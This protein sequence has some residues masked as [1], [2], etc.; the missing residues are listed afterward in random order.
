MAESGPRARTRHTH[1]LSL[2]PLSSLKACKHIILY[3]TSYPEIERISPCDPSNDVGQRLPVS[4]LT[5]HWIR[6][7]QIKLWPRG[8]CS[9]RNGGA[10]DVLA[11]HTH[12]H[13]HTSMQT[14]THTHTHT[15]MQTHTH[16]HTRTHTCTHTCVWRHTHTRRHTHA[17][18]HI[19][20]T[21]TNK[22]THARKHTHAYT[23]TNTHVSV[24]HVKAVWRPVNPQPQAAKLFSVRWFIL[25][26]HFR[27]VI[28]CAS[29]A[30]VL[31]S[32]LGVSWIRRKWY[33]L[34][35]RNVM[36]FTVGYTC[37][38]VSTLS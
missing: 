18:A 30:E 37:L 26:T 13:M 27:R 9:L 20:H 35:K 8:L 31:G 19:P 21:R 24:A 5:P 32:N 7:V 16:T 12:T 11:T 4:V 33:S 3:M 22:H 10:L 34:R 14:H 15:S 6:H 2:S 36:S 17:R 29:K 1:T 23:D 25:V 38:C 28:T